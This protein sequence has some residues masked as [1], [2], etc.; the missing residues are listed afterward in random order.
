MS[1]KRRADQ[2]TWAG[3]IVV[4]KDDGIYKTVT[5]E[6]W[7]N[8]KNY[9]NECKKIYDNSESPKFEFNRLEIIEGFLYHLAMT[10]GI[11]F[12]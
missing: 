9:L 5:Q 4:T 8:S 7:E 1:R 2:G 12:P 3:G 11:L 6:K 10:F